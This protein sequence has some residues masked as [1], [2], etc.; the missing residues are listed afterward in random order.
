MKFRA[1]YIVFLFVF[2]ISAAASAQVD[3]TIAPQQYKRANP[4]KNKSKASTDF[5]ERSVV[6]LTS[7]LKLDD[8]QAA[9]IRDI[10]EQERDHI[11]SL[12]TIQGITTDERRDMAVDI[13]NRIYKQ[14]LPLLSKDQ[15]EKY[16]KMEESKKF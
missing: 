14:V 8:F 5:V 13:S 3:R 10:L 1:S 11:T 9:A 16:T 4:N 12:N 7:T 15:A 2:F 6:Y